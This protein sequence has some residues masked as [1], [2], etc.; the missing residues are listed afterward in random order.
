MTYQDHCVPMLT[1]SPGGRSRVATGR[2]LG[3]TSVVERR[4]RMPRVRCAKV[5]RVEVW[6]A[7]IFRITS[8]AGHCV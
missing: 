4:E 8:Q 7:A 5:N 2:V 6:E 1:C 3:H